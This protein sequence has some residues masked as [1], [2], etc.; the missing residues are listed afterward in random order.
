MTKHTRGFNKGVDRLPRKTFDSFT[1]C[2]ECGASVRISNLSD[3]LAR[4]HKQVS[5][6]KLL[7]A[8]A[9]ARFERSHRAELIKMHE[10][11]IERIR[12]N[13]EIVA[14]YVRPAPREK[15]PKAVRAAVRAYEEFEQMKDEVASAAERSGKF[16]KAILDMERIMEEEIEKGMP[17]DEAEKLARKIQFEIIYRWKPAFDAYTV[18]LFFTRERCEQCPRQDKEETGCAEGFDICI[19]D[20]DFI[21]FQNELVKR[22]VEQLKQGI[23]PQEL[24]VPKEIEERVLAERK[25]ADEFWQA[26][27]EAREKISRRSRA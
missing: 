11:M 15:P 12:S 10:R 6:E 3:H 22:L 9:I 14:D 19:Y 23:E 5:D 16:A 4:V 13:P 17:R 27:N 25:R 2:P 8:G 24:N 1:T 7:T 20:S 21:P 18:E 26:V